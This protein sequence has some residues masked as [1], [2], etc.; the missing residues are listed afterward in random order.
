MRLHGKPMIA[1]NGYPWMGTV[2]LMKDSAVHTLK[3]GKKQWRGFGVFEESRKKDDKYKGEKADVS[4][5]MTTATNF[6]LADMLI[7][8]PKGTRLLVAGE[9]TYSEF[10][11]QKNGKAT[12]DLVVEFVH[13]QHNYRAAQNDEPEDDPYGDMPEDAYGNSYDPGF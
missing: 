2:K 6:E 9:M 8:W 3:N 5:G 7:A 10:W 11:S 4:V 13:D 1:S 12:Y